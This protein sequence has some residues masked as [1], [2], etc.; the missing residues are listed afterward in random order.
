M[1][2][3]ADRKLAGLLRHAQ[4]VGMDRR[5]RGRHQRHEAECCCQARHGRGGAHDTAG[6]GRRRQLA[7]DLADP[8]GRDGAGAVLRPVAAAIGAGGEPLALEALGQ[9]RAGDQHHAGHV[10]AGRG[11]QLGRHRLVTA[12]D[13][14]RGVHWLRG[15]H[16]L[17]VERHEVA[18][19]HRGRRQR[20]LAEADGGEAQR[21]G[22][23]AK[24][25]AL[26]RL[27]QLGHR[28]VAVVVVRCRIGDADHRLLQRLARI[29]H[30]GGEGAPEIQREFAVAVVGDVAGQALRIVGHSLSPSAPVG[31]RRRHDSAAG[32]AGPASRSQPFRRRYPATTVSGYRSA[33]LGLFP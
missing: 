20:G 17:G 12:A 5:R 3:E 7:L 22:A 8:L 13:Q 1:G 11:H 32:A 28:A 26:H 31:T 33:E 16:R 19:V 21:Q 15:Q 18:I 10:G 23:G 14:H 2:D 6:A 30:R 25:A 27:D 4:P 29:A 24:H 9:H